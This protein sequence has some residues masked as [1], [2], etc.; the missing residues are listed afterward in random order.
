LIEIWHSLLLAESQ[1]T[2]AFHHLTIS[3][4]FT[5]ESALVIA[6]FIPQIPENS[7]EPDSTTSIAA[8][9]RA[10]TVITQLW[11][12]M[13]NAFTSKC[14]S[15]A[16]KIILTNL[17]KYEFSL[18]YKSVLDRWSKL[19]ADLIVAA[20][21]LWTQELFA[22]SS[23]QTT[24]TI[25][26]QLWSL[27]AQ[28]LISQSKISCWLDIVKLLVVPLGYV[29][30][31]LSLNYINNHFRLWTMSDVELDVWNSL[32]QK[33]LTSASQSSTKLSTVIDAIAQAVLP[34]AC[35]DR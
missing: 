35:V 19:C 9:V 24:E 15:T 29:T 18:S 17:L 5:E 12:T 16:A 33:T 25:T 32:L 23:S 22:M 34:V 2:Q 6:G 1:L 10:L 8:Q 3:A 21:P 27:V 4:N 26:R 7:E 13:K 11:S 20:M 28:S 30:H 14:I 31:I